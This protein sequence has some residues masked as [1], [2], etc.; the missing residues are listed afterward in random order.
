MRP[1]PIVRTDIG[2]AAAAVPS[3]DFAVE[4]AGVLQ[5]AAAPTLELQLRVDA[6]DADV[7]SLLLAAQ[8]RILAPART[9][10]S[11]TAAR[12]EE[13]FGPR[14]DWGRNLRAVPWLEQTMVVPAFSGRT[15]V[16]LRVP[17]G[18]DFDITASKYLY[19]VRDGV[20]PLE[21]LFSGSVFFTTPAGAL[22]TVR[23]PWDREARY[24]MPAQLWHDLMGAYFP[25]TAWLRVRRDVFD[26]LNSFRAGQVP[27]TWDN[28]LET[29][30]NQEPR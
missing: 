6:G 26:R 11:A 2:G 16:P 24:D 5:H 10:D 8:V 17:C 14:A 15:T 3:L 27:P 1:M 9:Y 4:A 18:Y 28:A 7:R 20:I 21:L 30:L 12:L 22:Q 23:L 13:L 19:A 25:N 29:L